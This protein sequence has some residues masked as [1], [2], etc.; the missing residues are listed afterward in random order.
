MAGGRGGEA[1]VGAFISSELQAHCV[2]VWGGS[3]GWV[4]GRQSQH[5]VGYAPWDEQ[6]GAGLPTLTPHRGDG[7]D[8][9]TQP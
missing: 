7:R 3:G 8:G 6:E 9:V 1:G 4:E 5:T 2:E